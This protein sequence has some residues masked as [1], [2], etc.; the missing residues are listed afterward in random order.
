[1]KIVHKQK[2]IDQGVELDG[3]LFTECEFTRCN[4]LYTGN[5]QMDLVQCNIVDCR[6]LF[7]GV[8]AEVR[9]VL[10]RMG[11]EPP[12][13]RSHPFPGGLPATGNWQN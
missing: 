12:V 8:A 4:L 7:Y 9:R 1:V 13:D 6:F 5:G 10:A 3:T 2:F 11:W